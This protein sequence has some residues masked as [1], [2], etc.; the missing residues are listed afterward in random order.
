MEGTRYHIVKLYP[1]QLAEPNGQ[2]TSWLCF[3]LSQEEGRKK[4]SPHL[5]FTRWNHPRCSKFCSCSVCVWIVSGKFLKVVWKMPEGFLEGRPGYSA[6]CFWEPK[7]SHWKTAIYWVKTRSTEYFWGWG[8]G[9]SH[10]TGHRLVSPVTQIM[11]PVTDHV[12]ICDQS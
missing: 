5:A 3:P 4:N 7:C 12:I 10:G 6:N 1:L 2:S 11:W 8:Y 9:Q